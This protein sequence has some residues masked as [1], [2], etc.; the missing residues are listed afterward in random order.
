MKIVALLAVRNEEAYLSNCLRHLIG[1]GIEVCVIDNDS[2]DASRGIAETEPGVIRIEHL[3][4]EGFLDLPRL[5]REKERL[6]SEITADWFIRVDADEI[7]HSYR[8]GETLGEGIE[9]LDAQGWEVINFDEFVFLPLESEYVSYCAGMQSILHYYFFE[10][11]KTRLMR[12]WKAT[13]SVSG[14]DSGGHVLMGDEFQLSPEAFALRHYIFR[15]QE[16]A[17]EKYQARKFNPTALARGWHANRITSP[18]KSFVSLR[19]RRLSC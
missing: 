18:W 15:N 13:K 1:Q 17:F 11:Y 14:L 8:E 3:P 12:A 19:L 2:S 16:H 6:A 5:L 9:R 4:Y 7:M 10:P